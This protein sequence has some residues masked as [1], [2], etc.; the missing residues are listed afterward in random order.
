MAAGL[1]VVVSDWDGYR[2][3]VRDGKDG[4]RIPTWMPGPPLGEFYAARYRTGILNYNRYVGSACQNVAVAVDVLV[5][6]LAALIARPDLRRELGAAARERARSFDWSVI[7]GRYQELWT[8]LAAIRARET[9]RSR[10]LPRHVPQ[11]RDPF[12]TFAAY[13]SHVVQ[14]GTRIRLRE[15]ATTWD[16]LLEHP[17]FAYAQENLPDVDLVDTLL[18]CLTPDAS[19]TLLELATRSALPLETI[20]FSVSCLAKVGLVQLAQE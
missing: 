10:P 7:F 3:T 4:F 12:A 2:D 5:E 11:C 8:E 13:P 19:I 14:P 16:V 6:K 1:P 18:R 20:L 9:A 17:L 15:A